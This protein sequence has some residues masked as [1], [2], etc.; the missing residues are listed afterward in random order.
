MLIYLLLPLI[1]GISYLGGPI[2]VYNQITIK[3]RRFKLLNKLVA[4]HHT[5][6]P[7][8][9][10][11]SIVIICKSLYISFIQYMNNS[12]KKLDRKTY[13]LT[14]VINGIMYKSI[15]VPWKGPSP[16]LQITDENSVDVTDDLLP[17]FNH[18]Y[19]YNRNSLQPSFFDNESLT[20]EFSD[21]TEK[22][23]LSREE[24]LII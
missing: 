19:N 20:F 2:I 24:I 12:V 18:A 13:E 15:V 7:K 8:I 16:I 21:G 23:F 10:W 5:S 11:I 14:Y 6:I 22:K 1:A 3:Y 17:Y 4:S 9:L